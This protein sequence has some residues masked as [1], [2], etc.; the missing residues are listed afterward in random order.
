MDSKD[1]FHHLTSST[2]MPLT[3]L[4]NSFGI[5]ALWDHEHQIRYIGCTPKATEGFKIRVGSKHVTGSEGRSHKFSQAYCTGRMWRYCHKLDPEAAA[6]EQNPNNAKLAKK[7][8]TLFIRK[9]CAITFIE[10]PKINSDMDYFK[11]LIALESQVQEMAPKCMRAWEGVKF[12]PN[13]EPSELVDALILENP[14]L[15]KAAERQLAI[16]KK[17]VKEYQEAF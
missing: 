3:E 9:Y 10:I 1:I 11:Y 4:P 13:N 16:Y 5:Y 6:H 2:P 17:Y 14:D 12:K 15:R 8:R 7:L